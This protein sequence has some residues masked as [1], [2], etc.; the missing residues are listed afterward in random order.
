MQKELSVFDD[1]LDRERVECRYLERIG[2]PISPGMSIV[3]GSIFLVL[4][5]LTAIRSRMSLDIVVALIFAFMGGY[6]VL[7]EIIPRC[8]PRKHLLRILRECIHEFG[9]PVCYRCGYDLRG[10]DA[11]ACPE[12]GSATSSGPNT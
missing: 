1:P 4:A 9:V 7:R 10:S 11:L 12:C 5:C 6:F 2:R 3:F 8:F